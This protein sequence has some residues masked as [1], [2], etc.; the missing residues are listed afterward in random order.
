MTSNTS[1]GDRPDNV[2]DDISRL[3]DIINFEVFLFH[4]VP[5]RPNPVFGRDANDSVTVRQSR[6][7]FLPN[8]QV[9]PRTDSV[10][11][12]QLCF[13]SATCSYSTR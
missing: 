7:H 12:Y 5:E 9:A 8:Q 6:E 11:L 1:L 4:G 13:D 10:P 2:R 3:R